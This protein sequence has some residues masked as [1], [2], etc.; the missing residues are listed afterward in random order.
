MSSTQTPTPRKSCFFFL[1][2]LVSESDYRYQGV[3]K[4]CRMKNKEIVAKVNGSLRISQN[5]DGNFF[6]SISFPLKTR[7][8]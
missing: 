8:F 3:R 2:G 5:E 1:G 7:L 4:R 6:R